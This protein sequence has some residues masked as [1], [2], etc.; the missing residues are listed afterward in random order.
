MHIFTKYGTFEWTY[1]RRRGLN[2]YWLLPP[3]SAVHINF[4]SAYN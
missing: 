4:I 3:W 2:Y 1:D